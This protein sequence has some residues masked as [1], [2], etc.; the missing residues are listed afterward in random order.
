M[1]AA[2]GDSGHVTAQWYRREGI[3]LE[4]ILYDIAVELDRTYDVP[5]INQTQQ[6][7]N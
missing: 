3:M 7:N 5:N 1:T 2:Y 4:D 6:P